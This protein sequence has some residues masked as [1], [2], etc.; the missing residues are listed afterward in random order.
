MH[1][2]FHYLCTWVVITLVCLGLSWP[3]PAQAATKIDSNLEKQVLEIIRQHPEVIIESIQ[4]YEQKQQAKLKQAQQLFLQDL[5]TN[6]QAVIGNSPKTSPAN[7]KTL[8]VEFSD[9]QCPYCA[10]A[11]KILKSVVEKHKDNLT[12]VYPCSVTLRKHL[13]LLNSRAFA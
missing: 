7:S 9:F 8:L 6:P 1:K 4:A 5:K 2:L 10:E 13:L 3:L 11:H 12:L